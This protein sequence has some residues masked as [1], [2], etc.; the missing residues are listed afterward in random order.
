[1]LDKTNIYNFG[2]ITMFN[3]INITGLMLSLTISLVSLAQ[4]PVDS[5]LIKDSSKRALD[6]IVITGTLKEVKRMESPVPVEVYREA[7]LRKN[8]S[9]H[10]FEG[11]MHI[12]GVRPQSNCNICNAGDIRINGLPGPYTMVLIDGMPIMSSLSSVYGLSGIPV[13]MIERIE[14]VKGPAST[15]YGSEAIGGLIN[16]ITKKMPGLLQNYL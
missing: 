11:L 16:I 5:S 13:S 14:V 7:F 9:F 10:L 1:M 2:L 4:E 8:P 15:L 6:E 3:K 12:N